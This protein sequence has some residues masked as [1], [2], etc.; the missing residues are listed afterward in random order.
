MQWP[1]AVLVG[2]HIEVKKTKHQGVKNHYHHNQHIG[3]VESVQ[4]AD[5]FGIAPESYIWKDIEDES[6]KQKEKMVSQLALDQKVVP[7]GPGQPL[8]AL[9]EPSEKA[10]YKPVGSYRYQQHSSYKQHC[11]YGFRYFG[12]DVELVYQKSIQPFYYVDHIYLL[13]FRK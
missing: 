3:D 7:L 13:K 1:Y 9:C 4:S 6:R 5:E 10:L 8:A 2:C 12:I 11:V